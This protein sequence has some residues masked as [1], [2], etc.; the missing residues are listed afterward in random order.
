MFGNL[1]GL[2]TPT[3]ILVENN[4]SVNIITTQRQNEFFA[5]FTT[6]FDVTDNSSLFLEK[7]AVT[8]DMG[9]R[10][11]TILNL[12]NNSRASIVGSTSEFNAPTP[13]LTSYEAFNITNNSELY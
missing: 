13:L 6:L 1:T 8:Q 5:N 9:T 4:S 7:N 12:N 11:G 10:I 3:G 2:L